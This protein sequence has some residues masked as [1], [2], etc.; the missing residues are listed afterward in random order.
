MKFTEEHVW[1]E[2]ED[3]QATIG[4]TENAFDELGG[5]KFLD[6]PEVG[7][8]VTQDEQ[9]AVLESDDGSLD[10]LSPLDG[11]IIEINEAALADPSLI[12]EDPTGD[13]WLF[14]LNVE[15]LSPLEDYLDE[16]AYRSI[17]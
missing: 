3:D 8:D 11:E 10:I 2:I 14:R 4:V 15:D 16:A 17:V 5:I 6:L 9:V 1:I 13:G 7:S 12:N